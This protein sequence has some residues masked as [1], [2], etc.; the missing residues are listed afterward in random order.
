MWH[1]QFSAPLFPVTFALCGR[2]FRQLAINLTFREGASLAGVDPYSG[3]CLSVLR[4]G[5]GCEGQYRI[6]CLMHTVVTVRLL[7]AVG[8]PKL[9]AVVSLCL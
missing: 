3:Q 9:I 8:I 5:C 1:F 7:T 2:T 4:G 6:T